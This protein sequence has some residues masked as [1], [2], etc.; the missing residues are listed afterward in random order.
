VTAVSSIISSLRDGVEAAKIPTHEEIAVE[1]L[2]T[3][4]FLKPYEGFRLA[5]G[6]TLAMLGWMAAAS[7]ID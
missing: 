5:V 4:F 7:L 6:L 3:I 1:E 2:R